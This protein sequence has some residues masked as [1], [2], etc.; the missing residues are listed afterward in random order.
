MNRLKYCIF[1]SISLIMGCKNLKTD[2]KISLLEYPPKILSIDGNELFQYWEIENSEYLK[3]SDLGN[4]KYLQAY[5]DS[6][7]KSI[8]DSLVQKM[9]SKERQQ[10]KPVGDIIDSLNNY[11]RIHNGYVGK[12]REINFLEAQILN[13]QASRFPMFSQPTEFHAFIMSNDSLKKLR[14]Y[15]GA[16]DQPW[17]PKPKPIISHVESSLNEG[18]YLKYHLHNHYEAESDNFIGVMAPSLA[19]A[20]YFKVL[21]TRFNLECAMI[22]N[23][24]STLVLNENDFQKLNSH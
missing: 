21:K 4:I 2:N 12:I 18:W 11:D 24:F 1:I 17:P 16:S 14:I 20:H 9:I 15:F 22:T 19:D 8:G 3:A 13:Y 23:G 7:S 5:R 10:L 6:I